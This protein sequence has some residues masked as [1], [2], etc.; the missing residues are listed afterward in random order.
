MV[1]K[2]R[3]KESDRESSDNKK[4]RKTNSN[5]STDMHP[6]KLT[7]TDV[8]AVSCKYIHGAFWYITLIF[9]TGPMHRH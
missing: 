1:N 4:H 3:E 7:K 8:Y 5:N 6:A 9:Q 2:S